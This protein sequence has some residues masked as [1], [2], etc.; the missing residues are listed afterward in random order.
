[1]DVVLSETLDPILNL[2]YFMFVNPIRCL[3]VG[4]GFLASTQ[5]QSE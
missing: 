5:H 4:A 2:Q 3:L 1:M